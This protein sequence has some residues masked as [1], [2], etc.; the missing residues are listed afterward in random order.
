MQ[1]IPVAAPLPDDERG[2]TCVP[3]AP[4]L[5][6]HES[7]LGDVRKL[8]LEWLETA[9]EMRQPGPDGYPAGMADVYEECAS[10]LLEIVG[11]G[12]TP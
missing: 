11:A 10:G 5:A 2:A 3:P 1:R 6:E 12:A 7:V 8:A 9:R 4:V